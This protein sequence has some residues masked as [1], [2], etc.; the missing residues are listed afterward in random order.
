MRP[1]CQS[2]IVD[3]LRVVQPFASRADPGDRGS[4]G[5]DLPPVEMT[6]GE[7]ELEVRPDLVDLAGRREPVKLGEEGAIDAIHSD[8]GRPLRR[9]S[10][11]TLPATEMALT[12]SPAA[13]YAAADRRPSSSAAPFSSMA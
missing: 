13:R 3:P 10:I 11:S 1:S 2:A 9:V 8:A 4:S 12:T 7:R 6:G 5:A